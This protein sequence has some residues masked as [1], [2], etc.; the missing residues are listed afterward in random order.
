MKVIPK[1]LADDF[2][3]FLLALESD[4]I[5]DDKWIE[6]MSEAAEKFITAHKLRGNGVD[7]VLEYLQ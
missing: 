2:E 3:M 4:H 1:R 6:F 5:S 7:A